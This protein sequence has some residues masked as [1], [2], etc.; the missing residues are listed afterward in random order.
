MR[1]YD[2]LHLNRDQNDQHHEQRNWALAHDEYKAKEEEDVTW[3]RIH[4][5]VVAERRSHIGGKM[6]SRCSWEAAEVP[7]G[8]DHSRGASLAVAIPE[9]WSSRWA[10]VAVEGADEQEA[11]WAPSLQ[12][13]WM[14]VLQ[15]QR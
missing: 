1:C 4:W 6:S 15:S 3:E 9:A 11:S 2:T 7:D 12:T 5:K 8:V 13:V 10:V 14:R